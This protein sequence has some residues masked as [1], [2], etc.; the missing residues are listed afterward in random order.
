MKMALDNCRPWAYTARSTQRSALVR[1]PSYII[2]GSGANNSLQVLAMRISYKTKMAC[3]RGHSLESISAR[4]VTV[5]YAWIED[6]I[7]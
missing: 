7:I 5:T 6:N 2:L 1:G 4:Y 3:S